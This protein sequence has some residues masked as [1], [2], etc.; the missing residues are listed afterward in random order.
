MNVDGT[1]YYVL[2]E[3]DKPFTKT[4]AGDGS[5]DIKQEPDNFLVLRTFDKSFNKVD[6]IRV[7]INAPEGTPYRSA[8]FG[9]FG[10]ND[11]SK[12]YFSNNGKLNYV[13]ELFD[14]TPSLDG[15]LISLAVYDSENGQFRNQLTETASKNQLFTTVPT[16]TIHNPYLGKPDS[17]SITDK[18]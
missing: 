11:L 4:D 15:D 12:G 9:L 13:V 3:Y 5:T 2:A 6:S 7:S 8:A 17:N 1:P 16:T 10:N 18:R 14:Y